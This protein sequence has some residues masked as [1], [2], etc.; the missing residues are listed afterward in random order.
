MQITIATK[1]KIVMKRHKFI[2]IYILLL[3]IMPI[4]YFKFLLPY[5]NLFHY[6]NNTEFMMIRYMSYISYA[7]YIFWGFWYLMYLNVEDAKEEFV[8]GECVKEDVHQESTATEI[9]FGQGFL[10]PIKA[11]YLMIRHINDKDYGY[12][13]EFFIPLCMEVAVIVY[14]IIIQNRFHFEFHF[15]FLDLSDKFLL[16]NQIL[17]SL[18]IVF[19]LLS[20]VLII[21]GPLCKILCLFKAKFFHHWEVTTIIGLLQLVFVILIVAG[22]FV[23]VFITNG[24]FG[25]LLLSNFAAY[26]FFVASI[27]V[28]YN[29]M[30]SFRKNGKLLNLIG[31]MVFAVISLAVFKEGV[32][33]SILDMPAAITGRYSVMEGT[34]IE[35]HRDDSSKSRHVNVFISNAEQQDD[36]RFYGETL[37]NLKEGDECTVHYLKNTKEGVNI[38]VK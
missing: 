16:I 14:F 8:V 34:V 24:H 7:L 31:A 21:C 30:K 36:I 33:P 9:T 25:G 4:L 38:K 13:L 10:H 6:G 18:M 11:F 5:S 2:F 17:K 22:I 23:S 27:G 15:R 32:W 35:I 3:I 20:T 12:L 26:I 19:I 29:C 28:V 37:P 1:E